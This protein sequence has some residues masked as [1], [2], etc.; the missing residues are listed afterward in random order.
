MA[1]QTKK[2]SKKYHFE[3]KRKNETGEDVYVVID[4]KTN[5]VLEWDKATF[6]KNEA[7]VE[8]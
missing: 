3:G 6:K 5:K 2:Q 1:E 7:L 8:N 4:L